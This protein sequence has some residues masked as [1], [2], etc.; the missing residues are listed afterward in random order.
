MY[1]A[2]IATSMPKAATVLRQSKAR[3]PG[4]TFGENTMST[5]AQ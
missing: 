3:L 4:G 1:V 2:S 5:W